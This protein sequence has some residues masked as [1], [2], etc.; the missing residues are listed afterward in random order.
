LRALGC[1]IKDQRNTQI[2]SSQKQRKVRKEE[3]RI[4]IEEKEDENEHK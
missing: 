4:K 3:F 1:K 2:E